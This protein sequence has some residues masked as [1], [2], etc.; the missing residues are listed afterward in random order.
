MTGEFSMRD[1]ETHKRR[2]GY[3]VQNQKEADTDG[4]GQ[5]GKTQGRKNKRRETERQKYSVK[6]T[7]TKRHSQAET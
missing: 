4:R 5:R 7:G 6:V 1:R 3:T 2:N